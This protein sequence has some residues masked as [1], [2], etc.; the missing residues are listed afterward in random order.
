MTQDSSL[1]VAM[2]LPSWLIV[3]LI[4]SSGALFATTIAMFLRQI[5]VRAVDS[6][7]T[8]A[9]QSVLDVINTNDRRYLQLMLTSD[10]RL[11]VLERETFGLD[12]ENG[13]R[14]NVKSARISLRALMT[15]VR[16]MAEA[17]GIETREIDAINED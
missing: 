15:V 11:D 4:W 7:I 1:Q 17:G 3:F 14:G 9:K 5:N 16:R 13:I 6:Q 10:G 8:G 12:G 2:S